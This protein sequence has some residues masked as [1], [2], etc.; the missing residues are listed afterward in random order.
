MRQILWRTLRR[1]ALRTQLWNG[2]RERWRNLVARDPAESV[3]VWAWQRHAVYRARYAAM[4]TDPA[5]QHLTFVRIGSRD[6]A[7]RL[8][9]SADTD[10]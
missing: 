4:A 7:R 1:T 9:E 10:R 3:I 5:W 6:D 2:N 8:L